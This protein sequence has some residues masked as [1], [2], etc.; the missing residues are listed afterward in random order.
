MIAFYYKTEQASSLDLAGNGACYL[1]HCKRGAKKQKENH[2][3]LS[4]ETRFNH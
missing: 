2:N 4:T 1:Y 3:V